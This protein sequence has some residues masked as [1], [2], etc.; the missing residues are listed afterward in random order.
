MWKDWETGNNIEAKRYRVMET[1]V[2]QKKTK[3]VR[4]RDSKQEWE[5][6]V[7]GEQRSR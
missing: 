7:R 1:S 4:Y 3:R 5:R 2:R 6:Q